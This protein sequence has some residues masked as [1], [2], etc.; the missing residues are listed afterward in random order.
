MTGAETDVTATDDEDD[1]VTTASV[2]AGTGATDDTIDDDD[3]NVDD[4]VDGC[5]RGALS[6]VRVERNGIF[7]A[8]D[9]P[10]PLLPARRFDI[11]ACRRKNANSSS[12]SSLILA[13]IMY[14]IISISQNFIITS[15]GYHV[16]F[17]SHHNT[18]HKRTE[19]QLTS[20]F[21]PHSSSQY[22]FSMHGNWSE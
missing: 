18:C 14:R 12:S 13:C 1:T 22:T 11:S 17:T 20:Q 4:N 6:V 16:I 19:A 3:N 5:T 21:C 10:A 9:A 7:G 8:F 2:D 15:L